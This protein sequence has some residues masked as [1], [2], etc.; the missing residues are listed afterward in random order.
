M[1]LFA[2]QWISNQM[3]TTGLLLQIPTQKSHERYM[4]KLNI[5][6]KLNVQAVKK[7]KPYP[8]LSKL[9]FFLLQYTNLK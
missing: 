7:K 4:E 8:A 2:G 6:P 5:L 9:Q 1:Y 3:Q